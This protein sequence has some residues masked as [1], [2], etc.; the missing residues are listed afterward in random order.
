MTYVAEFFHAFSSLGKLFVGHLITPAQIRLLTNHLSSADK[1]E[2]TARR[3]TQFAEMLK[4]LQWV[5]NE[6][7]GTLTVW[8]IYTFS[9]SQRFKASLRGWNSKGKA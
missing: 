4:A 3:V 5:T 9:G 7:G 8:L 2:T 6:S 1:Q